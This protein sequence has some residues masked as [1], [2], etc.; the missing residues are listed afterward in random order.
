MIAV[1]LEEKS[2][3]TALYGSQ[4]DKY[5]LFETVLA[6]N[7][8][9]I[10]FHNFYIFPKCEILS[11]FPKVEGQYM[12]DGVQLDIMENFISLL[13]GNTVEMTFERL[14]KLYKYVKT[15]DYQKIGIIQQ[16]LYDNINK[17]SYTSCENQMDVLLEILNDSSLDK[18]KIVSNSKLAQLKRLIM[19][20]E[21][22]TILRLIAQ[23]TVSRYSTDTTALKKQCDE[24]KLKVIGQYETRMRYMENELLTL[25]TTKNEGLNFGNYFKN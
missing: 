16:L 4:N 15:L 2:E 22:S 6:N 11:T 8:G 3:F 9:S 1:Q 21:D 13:Y 14:L 18:Q 12:F 10:V 25:K 20:T 24:D 19:M 5:K 7:Q 23:E 17:L